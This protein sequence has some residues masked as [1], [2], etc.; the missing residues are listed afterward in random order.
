MKR[1][2]HQSPL[3]VPELLKTPDFQELYAT[4]KA[5]VLAELA[6]IS[7]DDVSAVT[8]TLENNAEL[9]TK[10][11]QVFTQILQNHYR[12]WNEKCLQM[13]GMYATE[14]DMVDV[15]VSEM[16]LTRQIISPGDLNAFPPVPPETE[17][18]AH[19]LTRYYL[20]MFALAST[21]TRPGYRFHAMTL[22]GT[23]QIEVA[24]PEENVVV[25]TYRFTEHELGGQTKDA[26][27]RNRAPNSGIVD[28]YLLT[29]Q[30]D[31][32]PSEAL[33]AATLAYMTS[34]PIAQETD[35][36]F[37]HSPTITPWTLTAELTVPSGPDRSLIEQALSE[38]AWAYG[39]EQHRLG[40]QIERSMLD[41]ILIKASGGSGIKLD[42][43]SP[44]ESLSC[45]HTE[46]PYLESVNIT[47]TTV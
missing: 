8:Q 17:S 30:G 16:G 24:S 18:N 45:D 33:K 35:Q 44:A 27:F 20:S 22:G 43:T 37:I 25:V 42:I 5:E 19:L 38:A 21:G 47:V 6:T 41:Y 39:Q 23:P 10:M 14:D 4:F 31:G 13:F 2:P 15:I 1:F 26:Q 36:L 29:H 32:S 46:A 3:P 11:L 9:L 40:G 7:P 12:R 28:G 34:H